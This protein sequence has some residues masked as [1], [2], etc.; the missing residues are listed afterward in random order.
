VRLGASRGPRRRLRPLRQ[1]VRLPS[2]S[3]VLAL[4]ALG[5]APASLDAAPDPQPR[6][7]KKTPKAPEE[8]LQRSLPLRTALH[9]DPTLASPL[10]RLIELYSQAD[11]LE[12]LVGV[13]RAHLRGYPADRSARIVFVRLLLGSGDGEAERELRRAQG[14]FPKNSFLAYLRYQLLSEDDDRRALDYLD[15]A[16]E[17]ERRPVRKRAWTQRLVKAAVSQDRRD[18]ARKHLTRYA[19]LLGGGAAAHLDAARKMQE[20]GFYAEVLTTLDIARTKQPSPERGVEIELL[21][22]QAEVELDRHDAAGKR[23]D[24]LLGRLTAD[25]WRRPEILRRRAR[26]IRSS[27]QRGKLVAEAKALWKKEGSAEKAL[28]LARLLA[29]FDRHREALEIVLEAVEKRP[30]AGQLE[31]EALT[32]FDRLR[33]ERGRLAF[34]ESR[35][36]RDA[37][38]QDLAEQ[39]IRSLF[40]LG[41]NQPAQKALDELLGPLSLKE[42]VKRL[43]EMA[44]FLRA[45]AFPAF[46]SQVFEKAVRADPSRLDIRRELAETRIASGERSAAHAVLRQPLPAK[47]DV[48]L[49]QDFVQ[50]MLREELYSAARAALQEQLRTRPEHFELLLSLLEVEGRLGNGRSGRALS[51]KTRTLADNQARFRRWLDASLAFYEMFWRGDLLFKAERERY[52]AKGPWPKA[53]QEQLVA[54]ADLC[55]SQQRTEALTQLCRELMKREGLPPQLV[56]ELRRRLVKAPAFEEEDLERTRVHLEELVKDDPQRRV[57]YRARLAILQLGL[58]RADEAIKLLDQIKPEQLR[59]ADILRGLVTVAREARREELMLQLLERVT[60]VDPTDREVWERYLVTLARRGDESRLRGAIHQLLRSGSKLSLAAD[61]RQLLRTHLA[62]S[63]W[64]SVGQLLA[65]G[66][67]AQRLDALALLDS[68]ERSGDGGQTWVW[69]AWARAYT[70]GRLERAEARDEAVAD[71]ERA[72][73]DL[74][75]RRKRA[76]QRALEQA[77][78]KAAAE[79]AGGPPSGSPQPGGGPSAGSG[80]GPFGP[81]PPTPAPEEKKKRPL[82]TA[83]PNQ[84]ALVLPDGLTASIEAAKSLLTTTPEAALRPELGDRKGP[85]PPLTARWAFETNE[86]AQILSTLPLSPDRLLVA[87]TTGTLYAVSRTTGKLLWTKEGLAASKGVHLHRVTRR[88]GTS[89]FNQ[90]SYEHWPVRLP[91]TAGDGTFF[92]PEAGGVAHYDLEG[93]LL[94]RVRLADPARLQSPAPAATVIAEGQRAYVF[95]PC[96]GRAAALDRETCKLIWLRQLP[97]P[98]KGSP[99]KKPRLVHHLTGASLSSGRLFVYGSWCAVL[100]AK[101]GAVRWSFEAERVRRA[102]VELRE[103]ELDPLALFLGNFGLA[104]MGGTQEKPGADLLDHTRRAQSRSSHASPRL[105]APAVDW[106][107]RLDPNM[108]RSAWVVGS[109]L[110]LARNELSVV[111]LELPLFPRLVQRAGTYFGSYGDLFCLVDPS[112]LWV[113]DLRDGTSKSLSLGPLTVEGKTQRLQGYLDGPLAYVSGA[114]GV[115]CLNIATGVRIWHSPWPQGLEPEDKKKRFASFGYRGQKIENTAVHNKPTGRAAL[116]GHAS[117]G[118]LYIPSE[119]YRLVA[120]EAN[121]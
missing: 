81:L 101:D 115:V 65:G 14:L 26:L 49:F 37:S 44:R 53:R 86:R 93:K 114:G 50:L 10:E 69:V 102:R 12:E 57:D 111:D 118:V 62:D 23:L 95:E 104:P 87:D 46:A 89:S 66:R 43:A 61:V 21:A 1:G 64:R 22:A 112:A 99:D 110:V 116:I 83:F 63:T 45:Q 13:Y 55:A 79:A 68:V 88:V 42:R 9:H 52:L 17:L 35:L 70:L 11:R 29:G 27:E 105:V 2:L 92:L 51:E 24:A 85:L 47:V 67:E 32:L 76:R 18:L 78:E 106:A 91:V 75:A 3:V 48:A 71:L 82:A 40:L 108:A 30:S 34:L 15:Q 73:E 100:D 4:G 59:D 31:R 7:A 28:D 103:R 54:F 90:E 84:P 41:R 113:L 58:G 36:K 107:A 94:A 5:L 8:L 19:A 97:Q 39:R 20:A 77:K 6:P 25:Y 80:H 121:K 119:P 33:D 56:L 60:R 117:D 98:H 38:R 16:I 109:R 72:L 120:L 74:A 96:T